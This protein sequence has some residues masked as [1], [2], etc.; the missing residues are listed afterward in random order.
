MTP[1]DNTGKVLA[2]RIQAHDRTTVLLTYSRADANALRMLVQSI[3]LK[4]S[5]DGASYKRPS[6]SLI[7][8]RAVGI[9]LERMKNPDEFASETAALDRM[10]TPIPAPAMYSKKP[11]AP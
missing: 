4:A 1:S 9:Y 8:R 7:A 10:V 3:A 6:L 2:K 11:K 5:T